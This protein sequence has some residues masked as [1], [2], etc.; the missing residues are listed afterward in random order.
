MSTAPFTPGL[1]A[2]PTCKCE[3]QHAIRKYGGDHGVMLYTPFCTVCEQRNSPPADHAR[4]AQNGT[5]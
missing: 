1:Y 4:A 3:T 2:C 5:W